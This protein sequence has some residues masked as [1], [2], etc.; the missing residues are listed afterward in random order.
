MRLIVVWAGGVAA[1]LLGIACSLIYS[2]SDYSGSTAPLNGNGVPADA[3]AR[4]FVLFGH[5]DAPPEMTEWYDDQV[6][7]VIYA[8][9]RGSGVLD[10][11]RHANPTPVVGSFR[12]GVV[13]GALVAFGIGPGGTA[14]PSVVRAPLAADGVG[15]WSLFVGTTLPTTPSYPIVAFSGAAGYVLGGT[16]DL[17]ADG[18]SSSQPVPEVYYTPID[19]ATGD[20]GANQTTTPLAR[21]RTSVASLVHGSTLYLIGGYDSA[22]G[23]VPTVERTT[24]AADGSLGAFQQLADLP[25]GEGGL[26]AVEHPT[27]CAGEGH[28]FVVGGELGGARSDV[29]LHAAIQPDGTLGAWTVNTSM[30]GAHFSGGCF[31]AGSRLYVLGGDGSTARKDTVVMTSIGADGSLDPAWDTTSNPKLPFARSGFTLVAMPNNG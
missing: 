5:R 2:G 25:D 13:D 12:A 1:S 19:P 20:L 3:L 4:V 18:G 23:Q 31:V 28:L 6:A 11:W 21:L 7:D 8:D 29:V 10:P 17:S 30:P 9:V 24:I 14:C 26:Y 22:V 15:E 16:V 27:L